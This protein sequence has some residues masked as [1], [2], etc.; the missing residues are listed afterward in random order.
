MPGTRTHTLAR[1][2]SLQPTGSHIQVRSL[3]IALI[4]SP[5]LLFACCHSLLLPVTPIRSPSL[6]FTCRRF[7]SLAAALVFLPSLP[8]TPIHSVHSP[9]L[10][11]ACRHSRLLAITLI[12]S[13]SLW[14]EWFSPG[15]PGFRTYSSG[16]SH[17][18]IPELVF[19]TYYF[20]PLRINVV[21]WGQ[22]A[23]SE[24]MCRYHQIF[25][26]ICGNMWSAQM[27]WTYSEPGTRDYEHISRDM[28]YTMTFI[29]SDMWCCPTILKI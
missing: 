24:D 13:P 21:I 25:G 9:S 22:I 4:H 10:S 2:T 11:F 5:S 1:C 15:W 28:R 19:S 18:I 14:F 27:R 16:R 6:S 12:C 17:S 3:P 8:G 23:N 7:R 26:I 29:C 20:Y